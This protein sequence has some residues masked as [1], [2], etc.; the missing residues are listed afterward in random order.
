M[1]VIP[2]EI[3]ERI[4]YE[5]RVAGVSDDTGISIESVERRRVQIWIVAGFLVV[6]LCAA[7][8]VASLN[9]GIAGRGWFQPG[10]LQ[11]A[12]VALAVGFCAYAFEKEVHLH[13]L[14]RLLVDERVLSSALSKRLQQH[15][16]L[17]AAG[18]ALNSVL[19]LDEVLDVILASALDML[20]ADAGSVML[21]EGDDALRV[22]AVRGSELGRNARVEIGTS[23]AGQVASTRE[24]L[25]VNGPVDEEGFPGRRPRNDAPDSA[26]CVPLQHRGHLLGVL[27]ISSSGPR[28]FDE[29]DL[30]LLSLFAEPVAASIA[31]AGLYEAEHA[32]VAEL[33]EA[34]RLRSQFVAS[35]SHE[36]RT[37]ITSIRGAVAASRIASEHSQRMDLLDVMERQ[38][39]RLADMVEEMLTA[40]KLERSE[41]MPLLRRVDLSA[42][43][44]MAALDSQVAGRPV[45]VAVPESCEAR[46]DPESV[47]RIV[48]NLVEN[49]HKYGAPPVRIAL[50]P[51]GDQV[52]L[53][54]VDSGSGVPASEREKIFDRFYRSD[55]TG[56]KPG[57]GLGLPIVR[58]LAEAC[59]G[60]VW[61]ED[62]PEGGAAFRVTLR[63]RAVEDQEVA[64]V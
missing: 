34:D 63:T 15:S 43:V 39:R 2:T 12:L 10:V 13:R 4:Q 23:I 18:K 51:D 29:Y 53:S 58:G 24:P 49:A 7:F 19:D 59:G 56:Q 57:V 33:L 26:M 27:N 37:P 28:V 45:D 31:K 61:V 30:Q 8:A 11:L 54:V 64:G 9:A 41:S 21:L 6:A 22:V 52:V 1:D 62:S 50:Q 25:I 60:S 46:A 44:R 35:V 55:T 36:L 42:L 16:A 20:R 14:S 48:G 40:A 5:A 38:A 47:R 32:H 3:R 17:M